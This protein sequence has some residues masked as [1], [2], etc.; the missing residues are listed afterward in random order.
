MTAQAMR[1]A[2]RARGEGSRRDIL[3]AA[4]ALFRERGFGD[5]S[6]RDIAARVGIKAGSIYY[7]FASKDEIALEVMNA[8][9]E[10]VADAVRGALAALPSDATPRRRL[11]CAMQAHLTALLEASAFTSAHIRI[12][13]YVPEPLRREAARVRG[14]Y[15]ALWGDLI[16][17]L[18]ASGALR[19]GV[20]GKLLRFAILG[21]LNWSLEW[22]RPE[23]DAPEALARGLFGIFADGI[24]AGR[25]AGRAP[26]SRQCGGA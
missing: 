7:H 15:D 18:A 9:I 10:V 13:G 26:S 1:T 6:L 23:G 3:E 25:D 17:A 20:D 16:D 22:Y 4:A 14:G 8:G 2:G 11:E 19:P 5:T 24:F 21:A 12:Y